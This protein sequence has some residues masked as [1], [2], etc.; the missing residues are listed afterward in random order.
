MGT[1]DISLFVLKIL[2]GESFHHDLGETSGIVPLNLENLSTDQWLDWQQSLWLSFNVTIGEN[3]NRQNI[4]AS[5][6]LP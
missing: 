3:S 5:D 4:L 2:H 1:C 6:Y